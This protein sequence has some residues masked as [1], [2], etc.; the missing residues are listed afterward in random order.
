[1][2]SNIN[3]SR[4][5]LRIVALIVEVGG[6]VVIMT[7]RVTK[8]R[9]LYCI[10]RFLQLIST[11]TVGLS[12]KSNG[13]HHRRKAHS[14]V[15]AGAS[16]PVSLNAYLSSESGSRCKTSECKQTLMEALL[17]DAPVEN[18]IHWLVRQQIWFLS[19]PF[20]NVWHSLDLLQNQRQRT[21]SQRR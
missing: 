3:G 19:N 15:Y 13:L 14:G 8:L 2:L 6:H 21:W 10:T 20:D 12:Q 17:I 16:C 11:G 9:R 7:N 4:L 1:M 18:L 5:G